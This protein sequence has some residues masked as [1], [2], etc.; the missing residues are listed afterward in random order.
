MKF[1]EA[2]KQEATLSALC[3]L[4]LLLVPT[5]VLSIAIMALEHFSK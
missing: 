2:V 1:R 5:T 4:A 3:V